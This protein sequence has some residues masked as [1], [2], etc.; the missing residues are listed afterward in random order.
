M[1]RLPQCGTDEQLALH[2]NLDTAVSGSTTVTLEQPGHPPL[3]SIKLAG[4]SVNFEVEF[5]KYF[6]NWNNS[7]L[8]TGMQGAVVSMSFELVGNADLY[9]FQFHCRVQHPVQD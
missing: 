2:L 7:A 5:G 8:S 9:G 4:N 1:L 6:D 3:V